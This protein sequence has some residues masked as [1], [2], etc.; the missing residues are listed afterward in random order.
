[1]INNDNDIDKYSQLDKIYIPN[2]YVNEHYSYRF[3][4]D[5]IYII[6]N[7]NCYN[8]YS[9]TYC[10]CYYYNYT[11]NVMSD[12]IVCNTNS[13]YPVI[14][15]EKVSSDINY[16]SYITTNFIYEKG[17]ILLMF[18]LGILLALLFTKR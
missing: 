5:Y 14:P 10:D 4:G 9:S 6:T 7:N 1:M 12:S 17:S 16:S 2:D 11:N 15:Y 18:I 8:Q 3:N 13:N